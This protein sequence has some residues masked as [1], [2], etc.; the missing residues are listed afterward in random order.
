M[1]LL[2]DAVNEADL[3]WKADVCKYQRHHAKYGAHCDGLLLAQTSDDNLQVDD[4]KPEPKKF[5][6]MKDPN[7][8]KALE[9]A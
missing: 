3:T 1:D 9:K 7:F 4:D 6:D 5:G 8:V 2:I